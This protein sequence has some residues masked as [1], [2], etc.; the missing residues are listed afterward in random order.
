M[1][2]CVQAA[3]R[4]KENKGGAHQEMSGTALNATTGRFRRGWCCGSVKA[5]TASSRCTYCAKDDG[6]RWSDREAA[7]SRIGNRKMYIEMAECGGKSDGA[8]IRAE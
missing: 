5:V 6:P 3:Q 1:Q 8:S 7:I 2:H 4:R